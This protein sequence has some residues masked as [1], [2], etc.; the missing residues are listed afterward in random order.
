MRLQYLETLKEVAT[1]PATKIV[2]PM[3]LVE[4]VRD[5]LGKEE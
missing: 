2:L 1:S 5:F 4:L 3:Q